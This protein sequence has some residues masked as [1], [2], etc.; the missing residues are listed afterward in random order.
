MSWAPPKWRD[1]VT[2]LTDEEAFP[3]PVECEACGTPWRIVMMEA[4]T[5][6]EHVCLGTPP[7]SLQLLESTED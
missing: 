2:G 6:G 4:R 3:E 7:A 1:P 5:W